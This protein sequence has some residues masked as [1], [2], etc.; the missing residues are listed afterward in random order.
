MPFRRRNSVAVVAVCALV[1][2]AVVVA[3]VVVAG[4]ESA[5]AQDGH[6]QSQVVSAVPA[7]YTPNI[8]NGHVNAINQV[9]TRIVVGGTFTTMSNAGS[10]AVVRQPYLFAFDAATGVLDTGFRPVLN[11]AAQSIEPGPSPDTVYVAGGFTAVNGVANRAIVLLSTVTGAVVG[12]FKAAITN[13]IGNAIR[14]TGGRLLVGGTFTSVSNVAHDG[15][16]SLNPTTG[17]LD[18][19]MTVQ[20]TGHHNYNG[21]GAG[22]TVGAVAMDVSPDGRQLIVIGNFKNANGVQ[23]DQIV[24]IDL[25]GTS[26]AVDPWNTLEYT[27]A[28]DNLHYDSYVRDVNWSPDGSYFVIASTGG[29]G[30]NSDGTRGL[31]DSA[32]R[33]SATDTGANVLPTWVDY[34]GSDSLY[35]VAVTGTAIYVGGHQRW[36]NNAN[37]ADFP[38]TGS[39]PRPGLAALDP[40]NG[41]PLAWNPGRNPRGGGADAMFASVNGLYVGS[42]TNYF[43]DHKY[44]RD[45]IG[46]FPL[47][48]GYLPASTAV[49][50]LPGDIYEAGPTNSTGAGP[51]DLAYRS[52]APPAFGAQTVVPATGIAWSNTR[53]AFVVGPTL[54]YGLSDGT[55]HKASF[56]GT[57]VGP[58]SVVDPYDDPVWDNVQNGSGQTYRGVPSGYYSDLASVT[59]A[60]FSDGRLYYSQTNRA[61]LHWR[62]FTPDSGIVGTT[63]FSVPGGEFAAV[64]GIF[65][66][67]PLIYYATTVSGSLHSVAFTDGGTNG[68]DPSVNLA[69]DVIISG[70]G[71]DGR[72][73]RSRSMFL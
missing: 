72:D 15:I 31:C 61:G 8:A 62:Y 40:V 11:A 16:V 66:S 34:T 55:F 59:G 29:E 33:W 52:D 65:R 50:A 32:V 12:P 45:K 22:G 9:G 53:G 60:F 30:T 28:C 17:A 71:I 39:V 38:G 24:K 43:G 63:E 13:G 27:A 25:A 20:L 47:A 35:S 44:L 51:D 3:G 73:W 68:A 1:G 37:Q 67:G 6:A 58:S 64:A 5:Q 4:V 36:L 2:S 46:F 57:T 48:G 19:F 69:T 70:P 49:P 42:D 21:S 41:V 18:P 23:H 10:S 14:L 7:A 26:S 54:F 56:N